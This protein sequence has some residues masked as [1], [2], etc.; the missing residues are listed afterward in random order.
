MSSLLLHRQETERHY[1]LQTTL[2]QGQTLPLLRQLHPGDLL[3]R[4]G[5]EPQDGRGEELPRGEA[6]D[7]EGQIR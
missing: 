5:G 6:Q 1:R 4:Q 2:H 7:V 3:H